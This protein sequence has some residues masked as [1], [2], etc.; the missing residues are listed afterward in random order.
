MPFRSEHRTEHVNPYELRCEWNMIP[1]MGSVDRVLTLLLTLGNQDGPAS[2]SQ[3]A[4]ELGDPPS[5]V[6]RLLAVL[7]EQ[8]LVVQDAETRKYRLGPGVLRL[9]EAYVR[10]NGLITVAQRHLNELRARTQESVFLTE[11]INGDAVCVATAQSP[12]P[13][14]YFIRIGQRMPYHAAASGRAILAFRSPTEVELLLR[15]E[16]IDRFTDLTPQTLQDALLEV[17]KTQRQ[18]FAV[19][20]EEMEPGV[21]AIAAPVLDASETSTASLAVV[22]PASRL[23]GERRAMIA[24]LVVEAALRISHEL[25]SKRE[26]LSAQPSYS[27]APEL[28]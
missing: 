24:D 28:A 26:F 7:A 25:G 6:H 16:R 1:L 10:S 11:F 14:S 23:A 17:A 12:R 5:T 18:G 4:D 22:A 27:A 19:C 15:A 2:V 8:K 20:D 21:T 13:L 9:S 3:L